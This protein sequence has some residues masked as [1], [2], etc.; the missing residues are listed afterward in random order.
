MKIAPNVMQVV[1]PCFRERIDCRTSI[2]YGDHALLKQINF[3]WI[4]GEWYIYV[5][6]FKLLAFCLQSLLWTSSDRKWGC[7]A[8]MNL[9]MAEHSISRISALNGAKLVNAR[10]ECTWAENYSLITDA[11]THCNHTFWLAAL[12]PAWS[13]ATKPAHNEPHSRYFGRIELAYSHRWSSEQFPSIQFPSHG[14]GRPEEQVFR[15]FPKSA[16]SWDWTR[17]LTVMKFER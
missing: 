17:D 14:F 15:H 2:N 1:G 10:F 7:K 12:M 4:Y 8:P 6:S 3:D 16:A 11:P 9:I 13:R 5:W